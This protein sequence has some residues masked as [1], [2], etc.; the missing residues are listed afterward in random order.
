[1]CDK[2]EGFAVNVPVP[3]SFNDR[4]MDYLREAVILP[5]IEEFSPEVVI[6]QGGAD[7]LADD[8]LSRLGL[9]NNSLWRVLADVY[10]TSPKL[11]LL[12]G[13]GYNPWSVARCWAG[14]C[15]VLFRKEIPTV[16]PREAQQLLRQI[17]WRHSLSRN[18]PERWFTTLTDG[19]RW[20][21]LRREVRSVAAAAMR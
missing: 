7:A 20:G 14:F 4:E 1:V 12:G 8:P 3:E 5:L 15:A 16:L 21:D 17:S 13:G 11:L 10:R 18:P 19:P 9:S 6:V 2:G